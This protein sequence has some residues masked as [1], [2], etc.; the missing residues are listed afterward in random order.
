M[1]LLFVH[2]LEMWSS[3]IP[4]LPVYVLFPT[5]VLPEKFGG[6]VRLAFQ[7]PYPIYGQNLRFSLPYLWKSSFF[8]F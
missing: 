6:G 3:A 5:R 1:V 4:R 2:S 7:N 8:F